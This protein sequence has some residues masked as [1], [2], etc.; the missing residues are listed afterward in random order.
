MPTEAET[1]EERGGEGG[2]ASRKDPE[3]GPQ[4]SLVE[5]YVARLKNRPFVAVLIV[6]GLSV[7]AIA[8]FT[9]AMQKLLG[10][11]PSRKAQ[12]PDLVIYK[13][14]LENSKVH[15]ANR[16]KTPVSTDKLLLA[17]SEGPYKKPEW[18][19]ATN[20][21]HAE[22]IA[23]RQIEPGEGV[24]VTIEMLS[25]ADEDTEFM[26]DAGEMV[27]E[28]DEVNNCVNAA[29]EIV[30]CRRSLGREL[31]DMLMEGDGPE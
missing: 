13:V 31:R 28:S 6:L 27:E 7:I 16:G 29:A 5:K 2:R 19:Y 11:L 14:D 24:P 4:E 22:Y 17:W 12:L 30:P 25:E 15:I 20:V 23:H 18:N 10:L 9:G 21:G 1:H 3:G 8:Q 26:I